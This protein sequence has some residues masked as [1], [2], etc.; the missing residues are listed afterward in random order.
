VRRVI[1]VGFSLVAAVTAAVQTYAARA[2]PWSPA[3]ARAAERSGELWADIRAAE[4]RI[5]VQDETAADL[6]R[7]E[8]TID[9]AEDVFRDALESDPAVW[10]RRADQPGLTDRGFVLRTL[11]AFVQRFERINPDAADPGRVAD[12]L[13]RLE[14][15]SLAANGSG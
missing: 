5:R 7:G 9:E 15:E 6:V 1:L 8:V 3:A 2:R 13:S 14:G 10:A 4:A 11:A 12:V